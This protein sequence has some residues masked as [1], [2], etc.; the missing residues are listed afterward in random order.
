MKDPSHQEF[1][2]GVL[3]ALRAHRRRF[4]CDGNRFHDAFGSMLE[5]A[6]PTWNMAGI[7]QGDEWRDPVFGVY[8]GASAMIL[9]GMS[10]MLLALESPRMTMA[11]FTIA[12]AQAEAELA[13]FDYADVY[14]NLAS[15]LQ[16]KL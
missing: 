10:S 4:V 16:T 1:Y 13:E 2:R 3:L 11:T 14:R 7:L 12:P 15:V 5:A 6:A 9:E 8:P